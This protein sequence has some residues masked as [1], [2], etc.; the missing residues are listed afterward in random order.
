MNYEVVFHVFLGMLALL[1]S[2]PVILFFIVFREEK[3]IHPIYRSVANLTEPNTNRAALTITS[4]AEPET[5]TEQE[6]INE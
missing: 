5:R 1:G 6:N 3:A 2:G 4:H